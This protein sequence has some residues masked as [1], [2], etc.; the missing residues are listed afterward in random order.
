M[1]AHGRKRNVD[2]ARHPGV[3]GRTGIGAKKGSVVVA[4]REL[5]E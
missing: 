3:S 5:K 1:E 2:S 4:S